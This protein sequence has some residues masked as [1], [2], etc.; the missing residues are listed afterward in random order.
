M[1]YETL[2]QTVL[3]A[4]LDAVHQGLIHGTSGNVAMRD[5]D[6]KVI[7]ITPSGVPY[8]GMTAGDIALC[9]YETL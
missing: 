3:D 2:R 6:C 1:Q 8:T 9:D 5:D 4:V 7:A